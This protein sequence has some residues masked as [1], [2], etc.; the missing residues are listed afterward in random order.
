MDC[1]HKMDSLEAVVEVNHQARM[2]CQSA[3]FARRS[4]RLGCLDIPALGQ[5][6]GQYET[7]GT[8]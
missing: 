7:A 5:L 6:V 2:N 3:A 4:Y 8:G 1:D